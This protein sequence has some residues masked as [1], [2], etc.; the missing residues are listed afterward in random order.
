MTAGLDLDLVTVPAG[1]LCQ[2]TSAADVE[3]VYLA[4][5][6]LEVRCDYF[7]KEVPAH[8]VAITPYRPYPGAPAEVPTV[9]GW[10]VDPHITRGGGWMHDRDLARCARRHAVYPPR[11]GA[12]FRV[13]VDS[14]G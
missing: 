10:A 5:G 2:G 9:E 3:A 8:D 1:T 4:H 7:L 11:R 6:D 12:G 13:V 14:S